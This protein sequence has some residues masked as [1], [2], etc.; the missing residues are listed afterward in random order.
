MA[1]LTVSTVS[2]A[3]RRRIRAQSKIT[4]ADILT[5]ANED[6]APF[7]SGYPALLENLAVVVTALIEQ[8][9]LAALD[10]FEKPGQQSAPGSAE[11]ELDPRREPEM[12]TIK[13]RDRTAALATMRELLAEDAAMSLTQLKR[14]SGYSRS[15]CVEL[16]RVVREEEVRTQA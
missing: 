11:P 15:Y 4:A 16:R 3:V 6:D 7:L 8:Q 10:Q 13:R 5:I 14:R 1:S 2:R 9:V 12:P